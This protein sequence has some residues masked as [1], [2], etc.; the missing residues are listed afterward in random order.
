MSLRCV[1][2]LHKILKAYCVMPRFFASPKVWAPNLKKNAKISDFEKF[3]HNCSW[4]S[5]QSVK[6]SSKNI[7]N[8]F[9]T[10][11]CMKFTRLNSHIY[12][13]V[14]KKPLELLKILILSLI[15][16]HPSNNNPTKILM[17]IEIHLKEQ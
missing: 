4:Q 6:L 8:Q 7:Q 9:L 11:K 15:I 13:F 5:F 2:V 12:E 14:V 16:V 10:E 3:K 17:S 1:K